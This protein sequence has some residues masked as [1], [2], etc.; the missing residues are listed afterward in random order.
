M[1]CFTVYCH[2]PMMFPLNLEFRV[3]NLSFFT[4]YGESSKESLHS[5]LAGVGEAVCPAIPVVSLGLAHT[6]LQKK[7]LRG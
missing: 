5:P 1:F 7:S 3:K 6:P 4:L 2:S